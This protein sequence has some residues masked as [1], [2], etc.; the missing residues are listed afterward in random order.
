VKP[1]GIKKGIPDE[2]ILGLEGNR[3][4]QAVKEG[5]ALAC[6]DRSGHLYDSEG[7]ADWLHGLS[8]RLRGWLCLAI[9]GPLGI[10]R[11]VLEK[12]DNVLSLS[13][14][15]F[16]HEMSRLILLEQIYRALTILRGEKYH[17]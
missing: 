15:T 5:D 9:G 12:S 13:R 17:K 14:L 11:R 7:L 8:L 3:I 6:L 2:E 1:A 4:L 10:D 16:T